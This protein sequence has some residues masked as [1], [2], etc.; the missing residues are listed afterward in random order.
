MVFFFRQ[1]LVNKNTFQ[2][3]A[4]RPLFTVW[5][6]LCQEVS[7]TE[8]PLDKYPPRTETSQTETPLGQRPSPDRDLT[9]SL[10]AGLPDQ[11]P[12]WTKTPLGQRPLDRDPLE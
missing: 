5:W 8:I 6:S 12:H 3:D 4:Y 1:Q 10:S 7:Q 11:R 2:L 9:L